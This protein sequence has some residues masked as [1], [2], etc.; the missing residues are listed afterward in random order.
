MFWLVGGNQVGKAAIA[1]WR[2]LIAP[3]IARDPSLSL[4][5]FDGQLATLLARSG[6]VIAETYPG[7]AY[8]HLDL[9]IR[10]PGH[11][12]RRQADRAG[13]SRA[14]RHWARTNHVRLADRLQASIDNGFG[15]GADGEDCFDALAGLF[16]MLDV[17]LGN[18][19]SGE[20][21]DEMTRIEGW[22]LGQ[23]A[24]AA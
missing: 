13:D 19:R 6:L 15:A 21:E 2:E 23:Q 5:P 8:G 1:G 12:K 20:P 16:G 14:L 18:R 7:E 17:V 11:S 22:I 10:R 4:W 9:E 24:T 3:A